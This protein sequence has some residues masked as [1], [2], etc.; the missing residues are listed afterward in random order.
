MP[1]HESQ[2]IATEK[3]FQKFSA[4]T[5]TLLTISIAVYTRLCWLAVGAAAAESSLRQAIVRHWCAIVGLNHTPALAPRLL[6]PAEFTI[7]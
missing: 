7:C 4:T 3:A 5:S 1:G 2:L 6:T